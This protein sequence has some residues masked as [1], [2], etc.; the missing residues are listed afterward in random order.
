MK[1]KEENKNTKI[2]T[3]RIKRKKNTEMENNTPIFTWQIVLGEFIQI[4]ACGYTIV[5]SVLP[6]LFN[7]IPTQNFQIDE[8]RH[9]LAETLDIDR[10][11]KHQTRSAPVTINMS[12]IMGL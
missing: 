5:T 2:K 11:C 8:H 6:F 10:C 1:K 9:M 12:T 3:H 7:G 4:M